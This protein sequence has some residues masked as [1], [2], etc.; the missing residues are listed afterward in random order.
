MKNTLTP[1]SIWKHPMGMALC[2]LIPM[3]L[4]L[5]LS[6]SGLI[7]EWG[8]YLIFLL[9]PLMHILMPHSGPGEPGHAKSRKAANRKCH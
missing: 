3:V 4:V 2:C 5:A 7:G 6:W 8:Y 9:C 1:K